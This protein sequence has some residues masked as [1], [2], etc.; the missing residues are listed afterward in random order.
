MNLSDIVDIILFH[1][2]HTL[3]SLGAW[4]VIF[5][6]LVQ[7]S[8]IKINPWTWLGRSI[9]RWL[10]HETNENINKL[11]DEVSEIRATQEEMQADMAK[12]KE[13]TKRYREKHEKDTEEQRK[14]DEALAARRRI[15]TF[16]DEI[17]NHVEHSRER[18]NDV[19][20]DIDTYNSY[21]A[22]HP[23]VK[24]GRAK[25]AVDLINRCFDERISK[26]DF[27]VVTETGYG[28]KTQKNTS[29]KEV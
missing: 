5:M 4:A 11:R 1:N 20:E 9:G 28:H 15:L 2:G 14:H 24:N 21:Y 8:P 13:E 10:N 23:K 16:S 18:F 17:I 22:E 7:V 6:S 27:L 12:S 26:N 25:H 19:L 3:N 29:E